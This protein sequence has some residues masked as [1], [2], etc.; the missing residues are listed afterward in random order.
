MNFKEWLLNEARD[1]NF[2]P[3]GSVKL[4]VGFA[5]DDNYDN[6]DEYEDDNVD[7]P[8]NYYSTFNVDRVPYKVEMERTRDQLPVTNDDGVS[9]ERWIDIDN[10]FSV[11][12]HGPKGFRTTGGNDVA[13]ARQVYDHLLASIWKMM[14]REKKEGREVNGFV[15]R[16]QESKMALM[17]DKFYKEYLRPNGFIK[18]SGGFIVRKDYL[19]E[20][21]RADEKPK[22][23]KQIRNNL[24][25]EKEE[26]KQ[27][28]R[29]KAFKRYA[30]PVLRRMI[31]H[32]VPFA[33]YGT[34]SWEKRP[35]SIGILREL[36]PL[37][38]LAKVTVINNGNGWDYSIPYKDFFQS[39]N[40]G[41]FE[42]LPPAT[43]GEIEPIIDSIKKVVSQDATPG[44]D[45]RA[46]GNS[47]QYLQKILDKYKLS[48]PSSAQ[49]VLS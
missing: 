34:E 19:R 14:K 28:R 3:T 36:Y 2:L 21:L 1:P 44:G 42:L 26:L 39:E 22:V 31:D 10:L 46:M 32:I 37:D 23:T 24:R 47:N 49:A 35:R 13:T 11:A 43:K 6:D 48:F 40:N 30:E 20:I 9:V 27:I 17:Y 38:G 12:F 29:S 41:R 7:P 45:L 8:E 15:F 25:S 18:G 5:P 16:P 4:G 33:S